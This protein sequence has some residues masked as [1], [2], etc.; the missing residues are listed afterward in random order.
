MR[1]LKL[2]QPVKKSIMWMLPFGIVQIISHKVIRP[3]QQR[4]LKKRIQSLLAEWE[5]KEPRYSLQNALDISRE[6]LIA[7]L[8]SYGLD[9]DQIG[10]GSIAEQDLEAIFK[11]IQDN[12]SLPLVGIHVGNFVGVSLAYLASRLKKVDRRNVIISIDPNLTHRGISNTETWVTKLLRTLNLDDMVIR[13]TGY[14]LNK[15]ISNDGNK[16]NTDYDPFQHFWK[17]DAPEWQLKNLLKILK[18]RVNFV[19]L[20]GNHDPD[21]LREEIMISYEL[22]SENGIIFLDDINDEHWAALK[23]IFL[24]MISKPIFSSDLTGTRTGVLIKNEFNII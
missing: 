3:Y 22:L 24:E 12:C 19:M 21:Y 10:S 14:S 23:K 18:D 8:G 5:S 11:F 4:E 2:L 20:D 16:Y 17:E 1:L 9:V 7:L 13:I 6:D 15:S